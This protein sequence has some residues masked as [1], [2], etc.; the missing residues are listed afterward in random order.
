[1]RKKVLLILLAV[2]VTLS[3]SA[4]GG[5]STTSSAGNTPAQSGSSGGTEAADDTVYTIVLS[6]YASE[7]IPPGLAVQ[8]AIKYAEEKSNGRLQFEAYF[9]GTYVSK[10]DTMASLK[11]GVIDMSPCEATQI[12]SVSVLNQVFNAL[13]QADM[14]ADRK[15][16]Q[17]IYVKMIE[18]IPELQEEMLKNANSIWLYPF[19][20]GGYNLHGTKS[21]N[22][23]ADIKGLKIEAHGLL[24]QLTNQNGGTAVEL[25]SGDYYNGMKLGTV[26]SQFSH[27]AIVNNYQLFEIQKTHTVFGS[28]ALSGG[29]SMPAM[30]YFINNDT[31]NSLPE[32]LQGIMKDAFKVGA[33]YVYNADAE[34]YAA[35]LEK[36]EAAGQEIIYITGDDRKPWADA[37]QPILDDWFKQCDAAGYDGK[38]VYEQMLKYFDDAA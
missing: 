13:I 2:V 32:D 31:W 38:A 18:E 5:S 21:V 15:A 11:T 3:I 10:D 7:S 24:G 36:C 25:D 29:L 27:W 16:V 9:S 4:C 12:A 22:S 35:A 30:G 17:E 19:V 26:D 8:E 6:Y 34:S 1:M 37:M 28:E 33:D 23:I 14:P 20:L